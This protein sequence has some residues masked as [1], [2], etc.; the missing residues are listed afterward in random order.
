MTDS[1]HLILA[2][3]SPYR[4]EL[5]DRLQLPFTCISPEVDETPVTG[6]QPAD[7]VRRLSRLKAAAVASKCTREAL[8]IGS[9]QTACLG[10]ST[11]GKPG[12]TD[13]A[14]EQLQ[15]MRGRQVEFLTGICVVRTSD[16]MEQ[17]DVVRVAIQF[18]NYSDAE[19]ERYI[20]RDQP[21]NCAGSFRCE[22]LGISLVAAMHCN[23]PTAI[24][25]LPLIRLCEMLR[26]A[27]MD[28]P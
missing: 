24:I 14:R 4:R 3:S 13:R 7:L 21:L 19:I 27:G 8:V 26:A 2:S 20:A 15:R 9:D 17:T 5:L 28:V 10:D 6:E 16:D 18:R 1:P 25:G 22:A 23:D 11:L 12:T